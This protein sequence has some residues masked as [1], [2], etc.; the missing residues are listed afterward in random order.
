[1]MKTTSPSRNGFLLASAF[2]GLVLAAGAL[3]G[4]PFL[5]MPGD[6]ILTFRQAGNAADF[7][8]NLG[9]ASNYNAVPVGAT[10]PVPAL[11]SSQFNRAF[12]SING[13]RWSVAAANRPPADPAFPL[14]TLWVSAPREFAEIPSVAWI[15][16]GAFVQGN[17]GAQIAGIGANAA[18]ASSLQPAGPDNTETGVVIPAASDFALSPLLGDD[19]NYSGT[20]QGLVE[21]VTPDDFDADPSR[22]S[23]LDLYELLPGTTAAGTL[24]APGRFLGYFELK[25]DG[26]LMFA[27]IPAPPPAPAISS[28]VRNG[29]VT[30]VSF[31]TVAGARYTL[32]AVEGDALGAPPST[33]PAGPSLTGDG[34]VQSLQDTS[35]SAVRFYVVEATH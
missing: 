26:T 29:D 4:A 2:G 6:L 10:I 22:V 8:I 24:N 7:A 16:K 19:G 23:R 12:P 33:W 17:A 35:A 34:S 30:L 5:H 20:F 21:A 18:S 1:M 13:V 11:T 28:I 27:N 15:R 25:P 14:Q 31:T 3:L 9:K 32:R